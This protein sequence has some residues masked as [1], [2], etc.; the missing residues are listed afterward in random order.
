MKDHTSIAKSHSVSVHPIASRR[1]ICARTSDTSD[2]DNC[3]SGC[4]LLPFCPFRALAGRRLSQCSRTSQ[5]LDCSRG[6]GSMT[7]PCVVDDDVAFFPMAEDCALR[8]DFDCVCRLDS[9]ISLISMRMRSA[10]NPWRP[11]PSHPI[12]FNISACSSS[13]SILVE[14]RLLRSNAGWKRSQFNGVCHLASAKICAPLL[15]HLMY[16]ATMHAPCTRFLALNSSIR[17]ESASSC[18]LLR[19]YDRLA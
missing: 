16:C 5:A 7:A 15:L 1:S 13:L 3:L 11:F 10:A 9:C 18:K 2:D 19:A 12:S 4:G 14:S 17:H 8:L 6:L